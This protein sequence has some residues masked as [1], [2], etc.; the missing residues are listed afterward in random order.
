M[1][2]R[3]VLALWSSLYEPRS[4]TA[5]TVIA[6]GLS[7]AAGMSLWTDPPGGD[8]ET[9]VL[10]TLATLLL[11]GGGAV[12]APTAW[13]GAWWLERTAALS[14]A[15]GAA[16]AEV[17]AVTAHVE[18]G[19]GPLWL[20]TYGLTLAGLFMLIRFLRTRRAP[21]APGRG[22]A[23]VTQQAAR[24]KNALKDETTDRRRQG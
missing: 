16:I 15:A 9:V 13:Q 23:S 22:P 12:G 10:R 20:S 7:A 21:Y 5:L 24:L 2:R 1:T 4:I 8:D 6:Y 11:I 19:D 3:L 14:V 18:I 17:L